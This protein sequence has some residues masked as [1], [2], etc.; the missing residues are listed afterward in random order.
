MLNSDGIAFMQRITHRIQ[1]VIIT[2]DDKVVIEET[3]LLYRSGVIEL[4]VVNN[5]VDVEHSGSCIDNDVDQRYDG[6]SYREKVCD[7]ML[8]LMLSVACGED[9]CKNDEDRRYYKMECKIRDIV[10]HKIS[11]FSVNFFRYDR[12]KIRSHVMWS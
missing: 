10:T 11:L 3:D 7:N 5:A 1:I 4:I 8:C 12:Y 9:A 2:V 6:K